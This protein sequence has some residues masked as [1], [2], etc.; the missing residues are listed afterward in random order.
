MVQYTSCWQ[1]WKCSPVLKK[2]CSVYKNKDGQKCWLY[3]DNLKL[4]EWVRKERKFTS[5]T[6]C[7]WYQHL[8]KEK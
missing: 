8:H 7:P 3:T 4:F 6:E 2:K 5:C 1:Y